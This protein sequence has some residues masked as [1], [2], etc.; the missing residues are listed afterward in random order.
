[1]IQSPQRS[2]SAFLKNQQSR[3]D[4]EGKTR[5]HVTDTWPQTLSQGPWITSGNAEER[6]KQPFEQKKGKDES[7]NYIRHTIFVSW[8]KN[9]IFAQQVTSLIYCLIIL[10]ALEAV[11]LLSNASIIPWTLPSLDGK[12]SLESHLWLCNHQISLTSSSFLLIS[13]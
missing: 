12:C 13:R 5:M 6:N 9:E 8:T 7:K 11:S 3:M 4:K 10:V 1:M 2:I